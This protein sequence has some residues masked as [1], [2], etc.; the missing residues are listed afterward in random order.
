M[1]SCYG[2]ENLMAAPPL[3]VNPSMS[4]LEALLSKLPPVYPIPQ[5]SASHGAQ[6]EEEMEGIEKL[7]K[8]ELEEDYEGKERDSS[9]ACWFINEAKPN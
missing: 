7:A 6:N 8:E 1:E 9:M 2:Q 5:S 3:R 4:S